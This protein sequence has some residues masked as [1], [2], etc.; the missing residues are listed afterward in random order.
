MREVVIL[1]AGMHPFGRFSDKSYVDLGRTAAIEALRDAGVSWREIQSAYVGH[2]YQG[3]C[4][5]HNVMAQLGYTGIPIY[6]MENA[7][8]SGTGAVALAFD[9]VTS[10]RIDIALALGME[11][12]ERGLVPATNMPLWWRSQGMGEFPSAHAQDAQRYL[13]DSE[14]TVVHLAK[15][16]AKNHRH[17]ALCQY[18]HYQNWPNMTVEDVLESRMI[19]DPL[20]VMMMA[21]A[22]DGAAAVVVCGKDVAH[23]YHNAR[24]LTIAASVLETGLYNKAAFPWAGPQFSEMKA[25]VDKAYN[26]AGIG[27][28][29]LDYL[30]CVDGFAYAELV[31]YEALGLCNEG[32]GA[33]II[34]EG[35]TELRGKL[36]ANT[37]GG[38]IARGNALGA[39]GL[40]GLV[41]VIRQLR[42]EA[43]SRQVAD[44]KVGLNMSGGAGPN[45]F[46]TILKK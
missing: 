35:I 31:S 11:K 4:A 29:D 12:Q 18:A 26:I 22:S 13:Y 10:G 43:S 1:G 36:P 3:M 38:Y 32:E 46:V 14:A 24:P 7:C 27:P 9:A 34:D 15:V 42:G 45:I 37:D 17:A 16:A 2:C 6:N 30:E 20:T 41:E 28:K 25:A 5:G 33:K 23:R 19:S 8:A 39:T 21:P 40:S 44:A